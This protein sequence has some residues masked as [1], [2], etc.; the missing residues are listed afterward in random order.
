MKSLTTSI[1][2]LFIISLFSFF[3]QSITAEPISDLPMFSGEDRS[4]NP[5]LVK[6]DNE[7]INKAVRTFSTREHASDGYTEH[8]FNHFSNN[9]YKQSMHRFNQA[10]LLN[11][12]N[13]YPYIG[14]GLLMKVEKK[15]CDAYEMFKLAHE[16][17]LVESGFLADYA[18]TMSECALEKEQESEKNRYFDLSNKTHEMATATDIINDKL[19]AYA[20]HSWAKAYLLQGDLTKSKEMIEQSKI[21]G[22][23]IDQSLID[24][25]EK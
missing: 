1:Y 12:D 9:K 15:T 13:P 24:A 10:W 6:L 17:G 25:L 20:Y 4:Q 21:F 3:S 7:F 11:P 19:L 16:K 5:E 8:G 14:F 22:G 2:K 18:Y 23:I